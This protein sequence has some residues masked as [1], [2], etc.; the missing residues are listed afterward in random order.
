MCHQSVGLIQSKI[1]RKG[2]STVSVTLKPEITWGVRVPRAAHVRF[3][4][5]YPF[6][7]PHRADLQERILSD[8]FS[9]AKDAP[10]PTIDSPECGPI[11]RLPY[12]WRVD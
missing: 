12:R 2:I 5:G 3:P 7:E 1:E 10:N 8:L 11:Y 4:L 9:I 6:G